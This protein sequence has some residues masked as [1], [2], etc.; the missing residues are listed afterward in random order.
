MYL[1][2]PP[3]GSEGQQNG[4]YEAPAPAVHPI[5]FWSYHRQQ[6]L[7]EM[8]LPFGSRKSYQDKG[9]GGEWFSNIKR[10]GP[11]CG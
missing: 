9:G 5:L 2:N 6:E 10:P 3:R 1:P 8:K 11:L 4:A 7:S